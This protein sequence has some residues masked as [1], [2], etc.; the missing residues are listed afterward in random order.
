MTERQVTIKLDVQENGAADRLAAIRKQMDAIQGTV[1]KSRL[2]LDIQ[3]QEQLTHF[4]RQLAAAQTTAQTTA[5]PE[6][7]GPEDQAVAAWVRSLPEAADSWLPMLG[8]MP[9]VAFGPDPSL[10]PVRTARAGAAI[11]WLARHGLF[12]ER[13]VNEFF[14]AIGRALA[15][16]AP[17]WI[18]KRAEPT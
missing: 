10:H 13:R 3:G 17:A 11:A 1:L 14:M 12:H 15:P 2:Q 5:A 9:F 7:D 16:D 6:A 8:R 4:R 18:F